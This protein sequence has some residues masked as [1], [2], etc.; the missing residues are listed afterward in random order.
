MGF[1][2]WFFPSACFILF[3]YGMVFL[4]IY[5]YDENL[6]VNTAQGKITSNKAL[7]GKAIKDELKKI[8]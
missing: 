3:L 5:N 4:M 8:L 6:G 1:R 2:V 7:D